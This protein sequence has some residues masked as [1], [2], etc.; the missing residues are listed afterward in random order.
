MSSVTETVD[1]LVVGSGAAAM[2]AGLRAHDLGLNV[3]LV[4][5]SDKYG[6]STAMSGGV[7]W[8]PNN[9]GMAQKGVS[10]SD[11]DALTYLKHIT[12]GEIA[13]ERL[14]SY[15]HESQRVLAYFN[16][17]THVRYDSMEKYTDYYPEAPGGR[18]GGRSMD[19]VPY[20]GTQLG[21]E[22]RNLRM[23]H[24]QSQIMGKFGITAA[25]AQKLLVNNFASKVYIMSCFA[26]YALRFMGRGKYGRDTKLTCGNALMGRLRRSL[27][28]RKV[29]LWLE[30]PA[31]DLIRED[32]R[33]VG[34][35]VERGGKRMEVRARL[36]VL[37]SAGGFERNAAMRQKW[38]RHPITT[39]WTAANLHN[40]GDGIRMGEEA[41]GA[42]DLMKESWWTPTTLVPGSDLGWVLVVE[43]NLPGSIFV[44]GSGARFCNE[45]APYV[46]VVVDMYKADSAQPCWMVFD[47]RFR[48]F[49]PVGPVA[50]G[51]AMPDSR[52]PSRYRK[53]FLKRAKTLDE[54]AGLIEVDPAALAATVSRFNEQA[55]KG[56]DEDF[57]RGNSASD[58]YYGDPRVQPNPCLHSIGKA[59][60]YA[61]PV[62]PGDLGTKGGLVTDLGGRVLR[63]DGTAIE[64]LFAAG[65]CAASMMGRTYPGAGGTIGPALAFGFVAAETAAQRQAAGETAV[66]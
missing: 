52:T 29:P 45:A 9:P 20:D 23:P 11:E 27:M 41:G 51:Y 33:V 12:E 65:N 21:D 24:P 19:A 28:D 35:V 26:G 22:L 17:N 16:E 58:R 15:I 8:V 47:A 39:E 37:L 6:G 53:G 44:N 63:E 49:Y 61:I 48:H 38:Q 40:V 64:G 36:G 7:C 10:D 3:L 5:K 50:P 2:A 31:V 34:A 66:A 14:E 1:F 46:D 54:L 30:S 43:K 25:D 62:Y 59:P 56:V 13:D 4:E 32:D 42:L 18:A 55:D 60:F 57:G